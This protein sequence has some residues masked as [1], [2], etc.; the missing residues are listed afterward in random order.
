MNKEAFRKAAQMVKASDSYNQLHFR[1]Y[2]CGTAGCVAGTIALNQCEDL[3]AFLD[4]VIG[5]ILVIASAYLEIDT[6]EAVSYTHLTLPTTPY[7]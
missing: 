2:D 4:L 1:E 6:D 5:D 7:V 3:K